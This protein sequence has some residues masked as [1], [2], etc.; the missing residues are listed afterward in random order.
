[1]KKRF[2]TVATLTVAPLALSA[3]PLS[4][5]PC[6]PEGG[7]TELEFDRPDLPNFSDAEWEAGSG[8]PDCWDSDFWSGDDAIG[9][10]TPSEDGSS[11][12]ITIR[13]VGGT[14]FGPNGVDVEGGLEGDC[15]ELHMSWWYTY[16]VE[17][18]VCW[19]IG[20]IEIDLEFIQ[21]PLFGAQVCETVKITKKKWVESDT[22]EIC[23][24]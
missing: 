9:P 10:G 11:A 3:A 21:I 12:S 15:L 13:N 14:L 16:T 6:I 18:T 2:V 24:C 5:Q 19:E 20:G 1:M 7:E 23:P 8:N 17:R 4:G 22:T